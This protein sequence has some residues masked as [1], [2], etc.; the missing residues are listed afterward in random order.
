M[1]QT[2]A[3]LNL[4]PLARALVYLFLDFDGVL[5]P[6][7]PISDWPTADNQKFAFVPRLESVLREHPYVRVVITSSWRERRTMDDLRFVFSEDIQKLIIDKTPVLRDSELP[8]GRGARQME[9]ERWLKD[10]NLSDALWVAAD[11]DDSLYLPG[12]PLVVCHDR[13]GD[14]EVQELGLAL[15][16]PVGYAAAAL[17]RVKKPASG[18]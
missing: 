8:R 5:H 6:F 1:T 11:D 18:L 3:P 10:N 7:F 16:D 15:T 4:T 14:R 13:I 12:A 9:V 2:L 17:A